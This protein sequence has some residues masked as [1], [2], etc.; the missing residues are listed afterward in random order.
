M[1]TDREGK[2]AI[3]ESKYPLIVE[4]A[5]ATHRGR[6]GEVLLLRLKMFVPFHCGDRRDVIINVN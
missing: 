3:N 6:R 1:T 2:A 5:V 4:V